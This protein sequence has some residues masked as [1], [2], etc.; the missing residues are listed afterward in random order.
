[1]TDLLSWRSTTVGAV[2]KETTYR[3]FGLTYV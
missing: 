2:E 1:V 3:P